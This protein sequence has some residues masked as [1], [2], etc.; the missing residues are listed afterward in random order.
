MKLVVAEK[1]SVARDIAA[2]IGANESA[3][4]AL[5]GNGYIVS[6]A[7]GHL[8]RLKMPEEYDEKY[9]KWNI[10]DLPI[11][12]DFEFLPIEKSADVLERLRGLMNS[13][14]VDEIIE[15]TDAG[16]EGECIFR[17]VYNY[18]GC[19]KPVK[20]LWI[21]SMT[22]KAIRD[23]F[24]DLRPYSD[25]D[26]MFAAGF[27]RNKIDWLWGLN[28][29]R[30]YTSCFGVS[31][32]MGRCKTA[33]VNMI[34]Q[35]DAE[36]ANF[37]KKP[38]FKVKLENGAEWF[39]DESDSFPEKSQAESV[40]AKCEHQTCTVISAE[41]TQKK[42][43]RPLLFSL[44]SLQTEANER[45]GFTAAH[46]LEIMQSLYEKKL[47]TY[48]RTDSNYLTDDMA[49]ILPERVKLLRDYYPDEV[50]ALTASGLNIDKRIIN[51]AKVSDHHAIIPTENIADA[52]DLTEDENAILKT[53]I[54]RF[55]AALS[56]QYEYSETEYVFEVAGEKFRCK[57]KKPVKAG[58]KCFYA[59][60]ESGENISVN[61]S[62]GETFQAENLTLSEC[63]TQ[64]P[65]HFTESTLLKAME[66]IDRRIEDKELAEYVSERGL[67]TPATRAEII[68]SIF[69]SDPARGRLPFA[70][71]KNKSVIAT[72]FAKKI[73]SL[74]P[75]EVKS[76]EMTAAMELQLSAIEKGTVSE[77]EVVSA[78]RE[79]LN[80]VIA[81][82]KSRE[83]TSLAPK[84]ER[85]PFGVCPKCG[86][87]VY[88]FTD[89]EGKTVWYCEKSS[90]KNN[91]NP[92]IF[93]V[94]DDD[95]FFRTKGKKITDS[96][97]KSLLTKKAAKVSGL[98]SERTGK[99]YDA[100]ISFKD[101][102]SQKDGKT[103]IGFAMEFDNTQKKSRK[104]GK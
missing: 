53:V 13:A 10:A 89:K 23:G 81:L 65:K 8:V 93:R 31:C 48:P 75:D 2:V 24:A 44:T 19:T 78:I 6:H 20:R 68:E 37:V 69:Q 77:S 5:R 82:E 62:Q 39:N 41:T 43:N 96:V 32:R 38:F 59:D 84:R 12:P 45:L 76:I 97:M 26:K 35:R 98:K 63:E 64:P 57:T 14:E 47:L 79:K 4:G 101:Y 95:Y 33:V 102:E 1:P 40:K 74:L 22:E 34:V 61:Y 29:T 16:R 99:T 42:E 67:G 21:S 56:A 73:I 27:T 46:T 58:W 71:R 104:G 85:E 86:A 83:H 100:V 52:N 54:T 9:A 17:Y 49:A 25:Y 87:N 92:C 94:Y 60:K 80:S 90:S 66:N 11:V 70:E 36:I 72:D 28:L 55:L 103:H 7:V 30:L 91:E 3:N 18:I 51:N 88:K 15:A 50:D